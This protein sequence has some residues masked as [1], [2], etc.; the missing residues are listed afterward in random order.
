MSRL[1]L[2]TFLISALAANLAGQSP[3]PTS[4]PQTVTEVARTADAF[5]IGYAYLG[6]AG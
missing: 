6:R 3:A 2:A 4:T 5:P 1:L